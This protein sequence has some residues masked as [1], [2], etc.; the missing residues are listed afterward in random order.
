MGLRQDIY[1]SIKSALT[2]ASLTASDLESSSR[3][4]TIKSVYNNNKDKRNLPVITI[5]RV[6]LP[7]TDTVAFDTGFSSERDA[8]VMIDIYASVNTH[9]E[10]LADQIETYLKNNPLG[11]SIIGVDED[12]ELTT[13]NDNKAHHKT[14][15]YTLNVWDR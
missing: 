5:S 12:D 11:Y 9:V 3:T 14:L 1:S 8:K 10:Q 13:P 6:M 7:S 15:F 4:V 2:A